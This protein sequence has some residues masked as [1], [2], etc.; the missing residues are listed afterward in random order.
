MALSAQAKEQFQEQHQIQIKHKLEFQMVGGLALVIVGIWIGGLLFYGKADADGYSTNV[1]TELLS[2]GITIFVVDRLNERRATNQR[3]QDLFLQLGSQSNDFAL[4]A[5]RQLEQLG[6]LEEALAQ[7]E[8]PRANWQGM[9]LKQANLASATLWMANLAN[10][11]LRMVDLTS[12][13]LQYA[14]LTNATLGGA[15]LANANA[16]FANLAGAIVAYSN[17]TSAKLWRS[18]LVNADLQHSSLE[19]VILR[20]ADLTGADLRFANLAS[21]TLREAELIGTNFREANLTDT[22]LTNARFDGNTILPDGTQWKSGT[23]MAR[24]T[25]PS[26]SRYWRSNYMKSPAYSTAKL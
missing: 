14:N 21:A 3:K 22:D 23:D 5:K 13:A 4:E 8:F 6:W 17:L 20:Y 18:N 26:H 9:I 15:N 7:K 12:A 11:D 1:F 2:V 16:E 25:D 19:N 10:A 24:F